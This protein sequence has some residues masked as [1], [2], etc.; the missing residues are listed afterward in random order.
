MNPPL[1]ASV[2]AVDRIVDVIVLSV[3]VGPRVYRYVSVSVVTGK[4]VVPTEIVAGE[5]SCIDQ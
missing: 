4:S 1:S 2:G 5:G 3:I